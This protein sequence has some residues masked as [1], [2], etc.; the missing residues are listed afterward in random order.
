MGRIS[1]M[2]IVKNKA[3]KFRIYPN[4]AQ[5][6]LFAKT[7]GCKRFVYNKILSD[8]IA[9]YEETKKWERIT[10]AKY[11]G[12]YPW[13]KEVDS[14]ALINAQLDCESAFRNFWKNP[15]TGFP[16]Y[17]TK[18]TAR[19][20]YTTNVINGN[21]RLENGKLKLPKAGQVR[22]KQ[23]RSIPDGYRLKSVTISR[24]GSG[25]YYASMLY[26]YETMTE[27]V[28]AE[29]FCGLDYTMHG[30]YADSEGNRPAYPGYYRETEERLMRE[31]RKLSHME[32]DSRNWKKQ[33]K[34]IAKVYAK[35]A[36]QRKDFLHKESRRIANAYDC[37]CIE[38]LEMQAMSQE[39]KFG[40]AVM[41]NGWGIF[42]GYLEYKLEEQGKR[43]I[44]VD[45]YY[46]SS[47][48]CSSCGKKDPVTK[49]LSVRRWTCPHCKTEHDRD[50]NAAINLRNEG[51][52][53][54]TG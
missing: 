48:T 49:D 30:L 15:G 9:Q 25:R 51:M 40:K 41:D 24:D 14:M 3:Y 21:I 39:M 38:D 47:Q 35:T 20:S 52:R 37:V 8:H 43:L 53:M 28:K 36:D 33:K 1:E 23:H 6:E 54:I 29:R 16:K 32:K 26:A 34:K 2:S 50:I 42:T 18:R 44:R 22:I 31:Q 5:K 10:P 12:A 4:E 27:P 7:F 11:K 13:L 17:K 46:P 19:Q 45:R